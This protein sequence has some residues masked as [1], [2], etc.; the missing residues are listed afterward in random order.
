[1]RILLEVTVDSA[2][3]SIVYFES[4]FSYH[5]Q[6]L[7][8]NY[9]FLLQGISPNNAVTKQV[10]TLSTFFKMKYVFLT[11]IHCLEVYSL[12]FTSQHL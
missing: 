8:T 6:M 4:L 10:S 1:M 12:V 5:A 11:D 3:A 9:L 7:H 2:T